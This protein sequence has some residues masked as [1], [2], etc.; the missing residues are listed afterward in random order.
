[1]R[2]SNFRK[3]PNNKFTRNPLKKNSHLY[4]GRTLELNKMLSVM[5]K[6]GNISIIGERKIGKT[7]LLWNIEERL[8]ENNFIPIYFDMMLT[9]PKTNK[10]FLTRLSRRIRET[11]SKESNKKINFELTTTTD[12]DEI[13]HKFRSDIYNYQKYLDD[14]HQIVIMIDEI[15]EL[16]DFDEMFSFLRPFC[17]EDNKLLFILAGY[18]D[19][20][21]VTKDECSNFYNVFDVLQLKGIS[22]DEEAISLI[23]SPLNN[24]NIKYEDEATDY[25]LQL[26]GRN[27]FYLQEIQRMAIEILNNE[28]KNLISKDIYEKSECNFFN[29]P[30]IK[31]HFRDFW[32]KANEEQRLIL[33]VLACKDD[34]PNKPRKVN[35]FL[36]NHKQVV[37]SDTNYNF[38]RLCHLSFVF[39]EKDGYS[40]SNQ[41]LKKWIRENAPIE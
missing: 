26:T 13:Y 28:K 16:K 41:L 11:L 20:Y 3:I 22:P 36:L 15:E 14:E 24:Y 23:K 38:E 18:D 34:I 30:M 35:D 21:I 25:I 2:L 5:K 27:P 8:R 9:R 31:N 40:L 6:G 4:K 29:T 33:S 7:S 19:L 1:M 12:D 37:I 10:T 39:K 32:K 17:A